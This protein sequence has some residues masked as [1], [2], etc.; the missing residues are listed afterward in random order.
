MNRMKNK[1]S[2]W[3]TNISNRNISLSDLNLT[4]KS[5][6]SVNLLDNK[7]YYFS[8]DQLM[9]SAT[10][11]SLFKKRDKLFVRKVAPEINKQQTPFNRDNVMPSRERSIY[12]IKEEDYE[13]LHLSD[14]EFASENADLA[15]MDSQPFMKKV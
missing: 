1:E 4:I 6:T 9:K 5:F 11:G 14:T 2:F 15:E 8:K 3:V 10:E 12:T 7:H 13:E